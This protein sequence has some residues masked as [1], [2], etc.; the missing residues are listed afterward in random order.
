M[1]VSFL[2]DEFALVGLAHVEAT[3]VGTHAV[4]IVV[5]VARCQFADGDVV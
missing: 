5:F 2:I 4:F 1:A 3:A